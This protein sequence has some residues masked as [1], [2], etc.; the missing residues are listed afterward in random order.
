M[1]TY[2]TLDSTDTLQAL[3]IS[4]GTVVEYGEDDVW[5]AVNAAFTAHNELMREQLE[6]LCGFSSQ[7]LNRY[8]TPQGKEMEELGEYGNAQGQKG[9]GGSEV[10]YPIRR[11][12]AALSWTDDYFKMTTTKD[13]AGEVT[14]I[15]DADVRNIVRR[16]KR[17]FYMPTN[18]TFTDFL[19]DRAQL[20]VKRLV[21]ADSQALPIGPNGEEFNAASHTHYLARVGGAFAQS[22]LVGLL[23]TV[24]E[25]FKSGSVII[26]IDTAQ[27]T[28]V[29]GF[30]DFVAYEYEGETPG[31]DTHR[32]L[33]KT[34]GAFNTYNRAIGLFRGAE[35]WI[36]PYAI[37]NY[38]LCI[39]FGPNIEKV[40]QVRLPAVLQGEG[41]MGAALPSIMSGGSTESGMGDLRLVAQFKQFPMHANE[42][43]REFD[44]AVRNRVAAAVLYVGDT[45]Y[46]APTIT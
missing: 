7:R 6:M 29:R 43:R 34:I 18:Y 39:A 45:T 28:A 41:G 32:A 46:A 11:F 40:L 35:V 5:T 19:Y 3:R 9:R 22:D 38:V 13:F 17:A 37:A 23:N 1:P 26:V 10:G 36:K 2:G 12:G 20:P 27:E 30:A 4:N 15:F 21:N 25:H 33:G 8:G 44:I 16:I 42:Y 14:Q 24:T 31:D